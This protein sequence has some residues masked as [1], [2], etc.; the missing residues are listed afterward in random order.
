VLEVAQAVCRAHRQGRTETTLHGVT[1]DL[2]TTGWC[3][4]FVRQCYLAAY[5][6]HDPG[7]PEFGFGWLASD[8]WQ[9]CIKLHEQ[10][11]QVADPEPGDIV[12]LNVGLTAASHGHIGIWLGNTI[13]EN[14]SRDGLG[15][16]ETPAAQLSH[17]ISGY[18]AVLPRL[19]T[20]P[21]LAVVY[22][23][24][25]EHAKRVDCNPFIGDDG[26]MYGQVAPLTTAFGKQGTFREMRQGSRTVK[27]YYVQDA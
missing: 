23:S 11:Y 2:D 25:I 13:A 17:R 1:F 18:Y 15:T 27:R 16:V 9:A 12:G 5:R 22:P 10:G 4:R 6:K 21:G 20:T 19:E 26:R 8:A 7:W 3:G 14:T 24:D